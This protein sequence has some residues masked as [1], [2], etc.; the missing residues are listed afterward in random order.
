MWSLKLGPPSG[1]L[2]RRP[3]ALD[4]RPSA[5][6]KP[7]LASA[8]PKRAGTL[9]NPW[10]SGDPWNPWNHKTLRIIPP[11]L[12]GQAA[13][14]TTAWLPLGVTV[15]RPWFGQQRR[16]RPNRLS[17]TVTT[18]QALEPLPIPAGYPACSGWSSFMPDLMASSLGAPELFG[19]GQVTRAVRVSWK[20]SKPS[21]R[22]TRTYEPAHRVTIPST[23][24]RP[25]EPSHSGVRKRKSS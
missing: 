9:W 25:N 17:F 22:V 13:R 19:D 21:P 5:H 24:G 15:I 12:L 6:W 2:D 14:V 20:A 4:R 11:E 3:S 7:G 10:E 16:Y 1:P 8:V 18:V 23:P